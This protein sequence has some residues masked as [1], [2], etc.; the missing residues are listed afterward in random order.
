MTGRFLVFW[1]LGL[2]FSII[3]G[4]V[5]NPITGQNELMLYGESQDVE[6][7]K[8]YAPE[9]EKQLG[10]RIENS[11]LQNYIDSVGQRVAKVSQRP[12]MEYHYIA[13]NDK[14]VNAFA[15]PGGYIYIT[16]G[17]LK[18]LESESQ[19]A[20]VLAHETTHVVARDSMQELSN[21]M[22]LELLLSA[23]TTEKTP[24]TAVLI[25]N[26]TSQIIGLK[27][28]RED[29]KTA[30]LAG[31]DYM[32]AAGYNPNGMAETMRIL[33][34]ENA[35]RPIKFLSTHPNPKNHIGYIEEKIMMNYFKPERL[36]SAKE[37]YVSNV[38]EQLK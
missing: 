29:E 24:K 33:Q 12:D 9:V 1:V 34:R 21:Q 35:V 26:I 28:S 22:G 6:M 8:K 20:S 18:K 13:L 23:V 38:L 16:S 17:L 27:Y 15:L 36:R 30:D 37:D 11:V 14:I 7:G 25:A 31:L 2:A 3:P 10:G 4:C 19:L 5:T 32:F